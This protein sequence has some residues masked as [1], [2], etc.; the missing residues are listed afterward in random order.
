MQVSYM[1]NWMVQHKITDFALN[2]LNS[3]YNIIPQAVGRW[4]LAD[5]QGKEPSISQWTSQHGQLPD[6]EDLHLKARSKKVIVSVFT[7]KLQTVG[8]RTLLQIWRPR[9][10][11]SI[12]YTVLHQVDLP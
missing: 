4:T 8:D 9:T 3:M 12:R 6:G 11:L 5:P 1:L 2:G 10:T 7:C